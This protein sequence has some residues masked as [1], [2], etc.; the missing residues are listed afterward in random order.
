ML[1]RRDEPLIAYR[2]NS[3]SHILAHLIHHLKS[4]FQAI[5]TQFLAI[6]LV[7]LATDFLVTLVTISVFHVPEGTSLSHA[8]QS[9]INT[10]VFYS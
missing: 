8:R 10:I 7:I 2:T 6:H 3:K 4:F 9:T 5:L 1:H